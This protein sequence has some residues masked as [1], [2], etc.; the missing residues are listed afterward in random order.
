M[1]EV[2]YLSFAT[3]SI[4]FTLS[5]RKLFEPLPVWMKN[6]SSFFG[7][8]LSC[9]YCF[10]FWVSIALVTVYKPDLFNAWW[11]LDYFLT[12]LVISWLSA[13]QWALMCLLMERAG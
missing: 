8:L 13:F 1:K 6:R 9:G 7:R 5:E 3:A 2:I 11:L 12:T 4:S 10:G